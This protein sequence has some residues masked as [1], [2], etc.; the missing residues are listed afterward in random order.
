MVSRPRGVCFY[1]DRRRGGLC[2]TAAGLRVLCLC[3]NTPNAGGFWV[4]HVS[5]VTCPWQIPRPLLPEAKTRCVCVQRK[6]MPYISVHSSSRS[7]G[8]CSAGHARGAVCPH[9]NAIG[10]NPGVMM[11]VHPVA[12]TCVMSFVCVQ[13]RFFPPPSFRRKNRART[14]F[15]ITHLVKSKSIHEIRLVIN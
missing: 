6:T 2:I 5:P 1:S 14:L 4:D 15:S 12:R 3:L 8:V 11:C 13:L 10:I 7:L 9:A